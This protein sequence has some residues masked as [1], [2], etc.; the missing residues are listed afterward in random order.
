MDVK[1]INVATKKKNK[2]TI[3]LSFSTTTN[4]RETQK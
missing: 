2:Q 3:Y 4:E 1:L